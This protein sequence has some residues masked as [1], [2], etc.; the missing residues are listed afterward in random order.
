MLQFAL[1]MFQHVQAVCKWCANV[2]TR[3]GH[4]CQKKKKSGVL[5]VL[6]SRRRPR[7]VPREQARR[8]SRIVCL[9]AIDLLPLQASKKIKIITERCQKM[10]G[11]LPAAN[12]PAIPAARVLSIQ[13]HVVSGYVGNKAVVFPLNRCVHE[14]QKRNVPEARSALGGSPP[15]PCAAHFCR[16]LGIECDAINSVQF[17]NHTGYPSFTGQVMDGD[18]L[19]TLIEGLEKNG[20]LHYSHLVTG[21]IGSLSLL[22]TVARVAQRL[23]EHNPN[24]VYGKTLLFMVVGAGALGGGWVGAPESAACTRT[25]TPPTAPCVCSV[26]PGPRGRR[27]ALLLPRPA[28]GVPR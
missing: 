26:R 25:S 27:P 9:D 11:I 6:C 2:S 24:L 18:S 14:Y 1:Q 23:R 7:G 19:W 5:R 21:Y 10:S 12:C 22:R 8:M 17:S 13:S 15:A 4:W 3:T 20:L 16:R 28:S